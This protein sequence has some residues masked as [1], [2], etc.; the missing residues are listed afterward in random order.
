MVI[1]EQR[2]IWII[3]AVAL[4]SFAAKREWISPIETGWIGGSM[5]FAA[6][7]WIIQALINIT[8]ADLPNRRQAIEIGVALA[9]PLDAALIVGLILLIRSMSRN[10]NPRSK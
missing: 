1:L 9:A 4:L 8:R 3:C 5:I 10:H 7:A 6:N 2:L